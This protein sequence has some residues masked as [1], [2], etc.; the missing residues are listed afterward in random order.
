MTDLQRIRH[1]L[2]EAKVE[3]ENGEGQFALVIRGIG[4]TLPELCELEREGKLWNIGI[5][6]VIQQKKTKKQR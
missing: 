1:K 3:F 6:Q 2:I 5:S 4:F